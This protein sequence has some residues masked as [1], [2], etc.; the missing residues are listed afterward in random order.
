MFLRREK[1]AA[2]ALIGTARVLTFAIFAALL[3]RAL[4]LVPLPVSTAPPP[5]SPFSA[6]FRA[7][8]GDL[9]LY[10]TSVYPSTPTIQRAIRRHQFPSSCAHAK[11]LVFEMW[12]HGLGSSLLG[13]TTALAL[14]VASGRVLHIAEP[15]AGWRL[16]RGC[17]TPG[18]ACFFQPVSGCEPPKFALN[19]SAQA[20]GSLGY[21]PDNPA[22]VLVL[23]NGRPH[24]G[25]ARR[26]MSTLLREVHARFGVSVPK[27][28]LKARRGYASVRAWHTQATLYLARLNAR[29]QSV[30]AAGLAG[31][32]AGDPGGLRS[33]TLGLPLRGSD[34]CY[35]AAGGGEMGCVGP[36]RVARALRHV[37][38]A[39]PWLEAALVTSEDARLAREVEREI[40]GRWVVRRNGGDVQQGTGSPG[41][42]GR[43]ANLTG[44][45]GYRVTESML[46]T[47]VCQAM[48]G[49]HV[50]TIRS[51]FH[52]LID[53]MA[54]TVPGKAAHFSYSI[55]DPH[56][57]S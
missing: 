24:L 1:L 9:D 42:V 5:P 12:E 10:S 44:V 46:A 32:A 51:N 34:K 11:F 21:V 41:K 28:R 7:M 52:S 50:L 54:K 3:I 17:P 22:R 57:P 35:R 38:A 43:E 26:N 13:A 39:H 15:P 49:F 37:R 14:A 23:R 30:A 31:C 48:P 53:M 33:R 27:G 40:G 56:F 2:S 8:N 4:W 55:G 36:A 45:E 19:G 18:F 16:A 25:P 6:Y 47:L 20:D 29:M